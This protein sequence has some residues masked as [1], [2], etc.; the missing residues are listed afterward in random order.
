MSSFFQPGN[1]VNTFVARFDSEGECGHEILEGDDAGY[2]PGDDVP[3][4][5]PCVRDHSEDR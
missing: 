3:S 5:G 2:L 1:R 4:C